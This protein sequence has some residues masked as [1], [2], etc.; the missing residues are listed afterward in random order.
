M[1]YRVED[2]K[3]SAGTGTEAVSGWQRSVG[4]V[5]TLEGG[6]GGEGWGGGI[7]RL[8]G[9]IAQLEK[10]R[11]ERRE[12]VDAAEDVSRRDAKKYRCLRV[13][14]RKTTRE[15]AAGRPDVKKPEE[16]SK[17]EEECSRLRV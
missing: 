6:G 17:L 3:K 15:L 5:R 10:E 12:K 2:M 1:K 8:A 16:K 11:K 13:E 7:K 14:A 9:E 4:K